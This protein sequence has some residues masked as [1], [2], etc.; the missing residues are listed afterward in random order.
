MEEIP[1]LQTLDFTCVASLVAMSGQT[2][3]IVIVMYV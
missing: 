3:K 2:L 1:A